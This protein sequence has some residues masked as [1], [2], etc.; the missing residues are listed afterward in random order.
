MSLLGIQLRGFGGT[1]S[2]SPPNTPALTAVDQ[3]DGTG[4]TATI[5]GSTAG[6]TNVIYTAPLSSLG[7]VSFTSSGTR[8]GDGTVD[9]ALSSG[10]YWAYCV[11]T[12]SGVSATSNFILL[13][14]SSGLDP[15]YY[16]C[17]DEVRDTILTLSL[18]GIAD[19]DVRVQKLPWRAQQVA[20]GIFITPTSESLNPREGT[21]ERDDIGYPV[22]VVMI[23][24]SNRDQTSNFTRFLLLRQR[25]RWAFHN[26]PM[27]VP[28]VHTCYVEPGAVILPTAFEG[29]FDVQSLI[30]RCLSRE[31]RG[32]T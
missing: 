9:L 10:L 8:V 3:E 16:Q 27:V 6:S 22:Q 29:Q 15:I 32:L 21:N 30:V 1:T 7:S 13:R 2:S 17:M 19:A 12:L 31:Q 25:I 28:E 23:Q 11:S 4:A 5:T 24:A 20:P 26:Q 18:S 14:V